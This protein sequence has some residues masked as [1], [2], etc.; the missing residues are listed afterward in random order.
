MKPNT[1]LTGAASSNDTSAGS[2]AGRHRQ[3]FTLIELV[4]V[5]SLVSLLMG[6]LVPGLN[7]I[8]KKA[9]NV[10]CISNLKEL[11]IAMQLYANDNDGRFPKVTN[12]NQVPLK[13]MEILKP[14]VNTDDIFWC[15]GDRE[16][17]SH[18]GGSYDWRVTHDPKTT[19]SGV[20]LDLI[21]HP[22]RVIIAG[23][24]APDIHEP[25]MINVLYAD[26]H[27]DQVTVEKWFRNIT[28]PIESL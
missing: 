3:A 5:I 11:Y 9:T 24:L 28:T 14:Y 16:K 27:V 26:G 21:R 2:F 8:R 10:E 19:L 6:L 17:E 15:P 7:I 1:S 25:G 18:P 12:Y 23:E 22:N 13:I 20:R 4:V